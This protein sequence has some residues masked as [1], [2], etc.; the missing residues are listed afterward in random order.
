M[1]NIAGMIAINLVM[2]LRSQG[3]ILRFKYP[4]ITICPASVPVMVELCPEQIKATAN[5][6]GARLPN[7]EFNITC[8]SLIS[9]I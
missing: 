9:P 2:V 6:V 5:R 3:L 1:V 7:K 8:A 4:S